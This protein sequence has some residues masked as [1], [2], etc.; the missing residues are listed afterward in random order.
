[1]RRDED[2]RRRGAR[3]SMRGA[4]ACR[5]SAGNERSV[6]SVEDARF[7]LWRARTRISCGALGLALCV[8]ILGFDVVTSAEDGVIVL[9]SPRTKGVLS[10]EEAIARRRSTRTF[11]PAPVSVASVAQLL[12]A[13]QGVTDPRGFRTAPSAGALFPIELY[14]VAGSVE[15]L[16]AGIYHYDASLNRLVRTSRRDVRGELA[17]AAYRQ[18]WIASA[19]AVLVIL[20]N[21][22]RTAAKYGARSTR[23]VHMEVGH[24]AQNIYLQATSL[25]LGTCVVG[26]FDDAAV[27]DVLALPESLEPLA[28]M[29]VGHLPRALDVP[30]PG[31]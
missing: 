14:L 27:E 31:S 19:P 29:P 12:W 1:M 17:V 28:L 24:V 7:R 6:R 13:A 11:G 21:P 20:A 22:R 8:G 4:K 5:E 15:G 3:G 25:E 9:P 10:L 26:A 23:Y 18:G 2:I 16:T 30:E